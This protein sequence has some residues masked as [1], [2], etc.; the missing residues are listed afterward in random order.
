VYQKFLIC[1][2]FSKCIAVTVVFVV[3]Y[4]HNFT[5][6]VCPT[7]VA[8]LLQE[9]PWSDAV[10]ISTRPNVPDA[11]TLPTVVCKSPHIAQISWSVPAGN[12]A[13]ILEYRL[14]WQQKD[15]DFT[16]VTKV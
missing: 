11:P 7:T 10:K 4:W 1:S 2:E 6:P 3:T 13:E 12:G 9:G 14:E 5:L 16:L 15:V 8:W